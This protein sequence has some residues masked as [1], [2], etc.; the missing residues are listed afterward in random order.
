MTSS[1]F[2]SIQKLKISSF[3]MPNIMMPSNQY[4]ETNNHQVIQTNDLSMSKNNLIYVCSK[5]IRKSYNQN[6]PTNRLHKKHTNIKSYSHS[7]QHILTFIPNPRQHS[8]NN[9]YIIHTK[10]IQTCKPKD[11]QIIN[12]TDTCTMIIQILTASIVPNTSKDIH[13]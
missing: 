12:Y 1:S 2:S 4:M 3:I 7:Y 9:A 11:N 8:Y 10:N 6:L 13:A 5:I